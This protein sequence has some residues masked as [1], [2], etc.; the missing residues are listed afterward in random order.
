MVVH[1]G[2]GGGGALSYLYICG[3]PPSIFIGFQIDR[4]YILQTIHICEVI[5]KRQSDV[6]IM[7]LLYVTSQFTHR[8]FCNMRS[9]I[10]IEMYGI[11]TSTNVN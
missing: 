8:Y 1:S 9:H 3:I 4:A 5:I 7:S 10:V 6:T 11:V 2:G